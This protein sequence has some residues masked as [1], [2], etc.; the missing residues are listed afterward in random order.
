MMVLKHAIEFYIC[1]TKPKHLRM[2]N[3][4]LQQ[5]HI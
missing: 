5:K 1:I 3:V 2:Y 4:V